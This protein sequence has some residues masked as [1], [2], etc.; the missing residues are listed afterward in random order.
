MIITKKA[1]H[2]RTMLRGIG[3]AI[4]LPLLDGMVPAMTALSKTAA[5]PVR[6]LGAFYLPNGMSIAPGHWTPA[7]IGAGFDLPFILVSGTIGEDIAISAM[8]E[9]ADDYLLKD[10]LTRLGPAVKSALE[11]KRLRDERK[12]AEQALRNSEARYRALF[13]QSPNGVLLIDLETGKTIEANETAHK[14][15][16]YTREEFSALRIS[17]N[18]RPSFSIVGNSQRSPMIFPCFFFRTNT[19]PLFLRIKV[20]FST[21]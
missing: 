18:L 9:G 16:G 5:K 21:F 2:R 13:E 8:K 3:A 20:I 15:L 6:R 14:Q 4:A 17:W 1:L 7:A 19:F 10:R 12:Q 11:Q